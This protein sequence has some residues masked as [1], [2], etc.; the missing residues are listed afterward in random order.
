MIHPYYE[1]I[2]EFI[3]LE[4]APC[5][6]DVIFVPGGNYPEA[7]LRAAALYREGYAPYVLPSGLYS[8]VQGF[9]D[10]PYPSEWAYLRD[11][12]VN[13]GVDPSAVLQE[14]QATFTWENAIYSREVLE[15]KGLLPVRTA[16]LC[17]QAFHSRRAFTYYQ[18]QF[19]ETEIRVIPVVTKG[20]TRD[21]WYLSQ[22]KTDVVLGELRRCGEQFQ[23]FLPV[24]KTP[25]KYYVS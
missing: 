8:K 2:S 24:T 23:C 4:D 11:I 20:I 12:L 16:L 13:N 1:P 14:D 3:F 19:P 7:A 18:Q 9:F 10:G 25:A 6:A 15:K 17:C 22:E 21:N 5:K